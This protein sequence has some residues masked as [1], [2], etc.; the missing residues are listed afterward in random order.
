MPSHGLS[1]SVS[2]R[3]TSSRAVRRYFAPLGIISRRRDLRIYPHRRASRVPAG[4]LRG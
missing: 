2:R 1:R 3:Q 4:R